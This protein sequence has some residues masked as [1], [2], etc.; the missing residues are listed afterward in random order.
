M[1]TK[2]SLAQNP[3]IPMGSGS[4]AVATM[5]AQLGHRLQLSLVGVRSCVAVHA[6]GLLYVLGP[7]F[8]ASVSRVCLWL[9]SL[10]FWLIDRLSVCMSGRPDMPR[11]HMQVLCC[12]V[13]Q[14]RLALR[15]PWCCSGGGVEH[16]IISF[17]GGSCTKVEQADMRS[18]R[19]GGVR[20]CIHGDPPSPRA[21]TG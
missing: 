4:E 17:E 7:G 16:C 11:I 6:G 8:L 18:V 13:V 21:M 9:M 19:W 12:A 20:L 2:D 10:W 1:R 14:C 3:N 15:C 5:P